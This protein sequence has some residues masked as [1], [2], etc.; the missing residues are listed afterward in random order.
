[1]ATTTRRQNRY[2]VGA[3]APPDVPQWML[4][5]ATDLDD[6]AY[7][8]RGTLA[9]RPAASAGPGHALGVPGTIYE[10]SDTSQVFLST[11]AAWLEF[12]ML[13]QPQAQ[14][15]NA[16]PISVPNTTS[17]VIPFPSENFDSGTSTEQ[18]STSTNNSRLTCRVAGLYMI[19]CG[20]EFWNDANATAGTVRDHRLL[21]NG[22]EIARD[23][24]SQHAGPHQHQIHRL[25]RLGV[26]DYLEAECL[27]NSGATLTAYSAF[28]EWVR[29]GP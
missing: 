13:P 18:H 3:T 11:G 8:S 26:G 9:S 14:L 21:K 5:L 28:L 10:A 7:H 1:M 23:N 22:S 24:Y 4:N 16:G 17:T 12:L 6:V 2:P 20:L 19:N 29:I 27:Q 25:F 15:V